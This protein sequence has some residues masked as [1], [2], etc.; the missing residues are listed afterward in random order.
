MEAM[1][2]NDKYIFQLLVSILF[3]FADITVNEVLNVYDFYSLGCCSGESH[4]QTDALVT[5]DSRTGTFSAC[6]GIH[7]YCNDIHYCF[8]DFCVTSKSMHKVRLK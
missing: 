4:T 3:K 1:H 5:V 7:E 6:Q 8:H 2:N